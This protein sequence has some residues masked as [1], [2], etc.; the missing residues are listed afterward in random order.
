M[1]C[2]IVSRCGCSRSPIVQPQGEISRR[3][4]LQVLFISLSLSLSMFFFSH[5]IW[6]FLCNF[7]CLM[8]VRTIYS[9]M[10]LYN[11]DDVDLFGIDEAAAKLGE[12]QKNS[13]L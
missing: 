10:R 1:D 11:R 9:F 13:P 3:S 2:V 12:I 7:D 4:R 8:C 5:Q 6:G